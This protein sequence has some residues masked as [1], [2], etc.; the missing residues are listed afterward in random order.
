MASLE[1]DNLV[2]QMYFTISVHLKSDLI[3]KQ[4]L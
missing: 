2:I 4:L 3:R 1:G